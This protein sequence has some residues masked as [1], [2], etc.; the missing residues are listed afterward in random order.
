MASCPKGC[1]NVFCPLEPGLFQWIYSR[2]MN[3]EDYYFHLPDFIPYIKIQEKI[4]KEYQ[5]TASWTKKAI[6]NVARSGK[7]SSDRAISEYAS[8]IWNSKAVK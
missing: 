3:E 5:D 2:I 8:I 6:L 1:D 7:F 4:E